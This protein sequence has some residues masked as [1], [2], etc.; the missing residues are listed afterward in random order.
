MLLKAYAELPPRK[1]IGIL[2]II[3]GIAAAFI[4]NPSNTTKTSVNIK[5]IALKSENDVNGVTVNDLSSWI[6]K[7]NMHYRLVDLRNESEYNIPTSENISVG[8]LVNSDLKR[9]DRIILYSNDDIVSSQAWFILK[10]AKF[11]SVYILKGGLE[12][13][14]NEVIFPVCKCADDP[15]Q[16]QKQIHAEKEE[17][18]KFFGGQLETG[19][20]NN[21]IVKKDTPKLKAPAKVTLKKTRTKKSREG[22]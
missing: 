21:A 19:G 18:A 14:K 20:A 4:G 8:S 11:K 7:G 6:I 5:E 9:N 15:D 2:A 17:I 10:S 13:W 12:V 22:C 16:E 1:R 3:L